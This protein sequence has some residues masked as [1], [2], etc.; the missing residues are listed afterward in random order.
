MIILRLFSDLEKEG[1]SVS[2]GPAISCFTKNKQFKYEI[3]MYWSNID[4]M[5]KGGPCGAFSEDAGFDNY[6]DFPRV[7]EDL[8]KRFKCR[9]YDFLGGANI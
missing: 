6:D 9:I 7:F 8:V 4:K 1:I 5:W 2:I 3:R